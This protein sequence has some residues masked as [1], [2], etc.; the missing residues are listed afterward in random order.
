MTDLTKETLAKIKEEKISPKPKWQFLLKDYIVW[1]VFGFSIIIGSLA[2]AVILYIFIEDQWNLY[3]YLNG[4]MIGYVFA[5]LPYVW[6]MVLLIFILIG[7]Y[8]FRHTKAG[9]KYK[10][11]LIIVLS[12]LGS[13]GLGTIFYFTGLGQALDFMFS[14]HV[15]MYDKM[16][17]QRAR[18][19]MN[20]EEGTLI[21]RLQEE[22]DE[23]TL[24]LTDVDGNNWK[25]S[26]PEDMPPPPPL[27]KI[28]SGTPIVA[29]GDQTGDLTFAAKA[30]FPMPGPFHKMKHPRQKG[31]RPHFL[32]ER[33]NFG[34]R[35]NQ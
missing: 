28:P 12:I 19:L 5:S 6:I 26:L 32:G 15:P 7:I 34:L 30:I 29:I 22:K 33:N 21:G 2:F 1:G 20:P 27:G 31:D 16:L 3:Q 10:G 24:F 17:E 35:N 14:D 18:Y 25:V 9:Y 13:L 8:N 23:T 4:R 11:Y